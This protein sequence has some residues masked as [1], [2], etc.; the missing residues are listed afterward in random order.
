MLLWG[1]TVVVVSVC[2]EEDDEARVPG[3]EAVLVKRE[4]GEAEE[5]D[6]DENS[7]PEEGQR[8]AD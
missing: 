6:G 4:E 8:R 1:P 2:E 7:V 3:A 5:V